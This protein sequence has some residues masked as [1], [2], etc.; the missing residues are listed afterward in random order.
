[1]PPPPTPHAGATPPM[2]NQI[3]VA[4]LV[5]EI[6]KGNL[7]ALPCSDNTTGQK[8]TDQSTERGSDCLNFRV[9]FPSH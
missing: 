9:R 1:M 2:K 6:Q 8:L 5:R 3:S 4:T 7:S